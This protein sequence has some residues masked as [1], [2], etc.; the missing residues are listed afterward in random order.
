[1][2]LAAVRQNGLALE[3]AHPPLRADR[4][5]CTAALEQTPQVLLLLPDADDNKCAALCVGTL[6]EDP[7]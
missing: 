7:P 4:F 3:Y 5:L 1:V 2:V 6:L